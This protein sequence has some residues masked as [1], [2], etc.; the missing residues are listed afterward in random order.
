MDWGMRPA[1]SES[2][3]TMRV[4]RRRSPCDGQKGARFRF[5]FKCTK[6]L[7]D[8]PERPLHANL[9]QTRRGGIRLMR[10]SRSEGAIGGRGLV[11]RNTIDL[12]DD[13]FD[14]VGVL[15]SPELKNADMGIVD[16]GVCR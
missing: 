15:P 14:Q 3:H 6:R 5:V 11:L 9:R 8:S 10:S 2:P 13:R 4:T 7:R 16:N 1:F 12:A